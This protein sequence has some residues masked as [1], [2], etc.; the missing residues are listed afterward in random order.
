[1]WRSVALLVA[2]VLV[3]VLFLLW[4]GAREEQV[5]LQGNQSVLL[6]TISSYRVR[7]SLSA[8]S[9]GVLELKISE[10][11]EFRG[12]DVK[13]IEDLG[14]RLRRAQ[15]FAEVATKSS[16]EIR[17]VPLVKAQGWQYRTQYIDFT[18][19]TVRDSLL[20]EVLSARIEVYDTIV[21]VLHRV[22]RFRFLGIWFGTKGVRQEIIS[23]NP[24]T[25]IVAAEYLELVK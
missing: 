2:V 21:Q 15:S 20:G 12:E 7:D 3:L 6:D 22:P 5:R 19:T 18:A 17:D 13:L 25:K 23:K 11:K 1:M 16:Y 24:H 10:M 4:R 9:I 14:V 8:A